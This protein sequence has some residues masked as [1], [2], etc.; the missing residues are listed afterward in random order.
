[1]EN[2][3]MES[4]SYSFLLLCWSLRDY[5]YPPKASSEGRYNLIHLHDFWHGL[6]Q[7]S[8]SNDAD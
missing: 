7:I 5:R 1:M 8:T 2:N 6:C 3:L 4:I